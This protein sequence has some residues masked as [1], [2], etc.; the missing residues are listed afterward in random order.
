MKGVVKELWLGCALIVI[1]FA[2]LLLSACTGYRERALVGF[3]EAR[4]AAIE[5]ALEERR[6]E[7]DGR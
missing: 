6:G 4:A 2:L 1:A 5:R 7:D 3:A